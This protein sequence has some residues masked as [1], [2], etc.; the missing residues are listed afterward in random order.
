[1]GAR[2]SHGGGKVRPRVAEEL[3]A[4]LCELLLREVSDPR[5]TG[6]TVTRVDL[7]PDLSHAKAYFRPLP[8]TLD[9]E[10]V[11]RALASATPFLRRELGRSLR[12]RAIPSLQL[13]L[14]ELPDQVARL[15]ELFLEAGISPTTAGAP[16]APSAKRADDDE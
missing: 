16:S 1:M 8:G 14:D 6:A 10:G 11:R 5:L 2:R 13:F 15:D 3:R 7:S 12:L 9:L 4:K